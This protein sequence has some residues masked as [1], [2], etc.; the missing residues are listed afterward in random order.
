[1]VLIMAIGRPFGTFCKVG[2]I[3]KS[4]NYGDFEV[5][6]IE[7]AARILCRS[8]TTGYEVYKQASHLKAGAIKD[9][10]YPSV[11]GVGFFGEGDYSAKTHPVAYQAW[12]NMLVRC[13]CDKYQLKNPTYKG[14]SVD[15]E[16]HN[17]QNFA[18]WLEKNNPRNTKKLELD[19]D[20]KVDGN[21]VYSSETCLLVTRAENNEKASCR[22]RKIKSPDGEIVK[23]LN[24]SKFCREN[25]LHQGHISSVLLGTR[26][27][28]KGWTRV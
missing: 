11:L 13:Y 2:D 19:K 14:C 18:E 17:F 9:P 8:I 1:M 23:V 4:K 5:I 3:V 22:E 12:R 10:H 16:W 7:R 15:D 24:I 27:H 26:S 25:D 21:K 20:I 6:K 28:H